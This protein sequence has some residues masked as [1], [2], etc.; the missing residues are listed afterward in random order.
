MKKFKIKKFFSVISRLN[1]FI[2]SYLLY[3]FQLI[4]I[5]F[6][7]KTFAKKLFNA[8]AY[9]CSISLGINY[10]LEPKFKKIDHKIQPGETFDNILE[11]YF[12]EDKEINEIRTVKEY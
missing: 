2:L 5:L 6:N 11:S 3:L 1:I 4:L 8:A 9:F 10:N 12:V 7:F